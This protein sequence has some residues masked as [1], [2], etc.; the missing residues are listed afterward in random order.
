MSVRTMARVWERSQQCGNDLL[1]LLAIAD[2]A[3]DDGRAYPAVATLAAKCRMTARN[4]N[5][6]LADLRA[7]GELDVRM[8]EGPKGTNLYQIKIPP[9]GNVT[10]D[11]SVTLTE[12]SP[13]PDSSVPKP[14]TKPSA[15]PS[16]NHQEPSERVE[17]DAPDQATP[18]KPRKKTPIPFDT[19]ITQCRAEGVEAIPADDPIFFWA[20]A[21][22]IPAEWLPLVWHEFATRYSGHTKRYADWR[23]AFRNCVRSNWFK[24]WRIAS[25]GE[26]QLTTEGEMARR[27]AL[28]RQSRR[29][30]RAA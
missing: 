11:N 17:R 23:A 8:N 21:A 7:S 26:Y 20:E 2:F 3:D 22:G 14:L 28:D 29:Q 30:E 5:R 4:A 6:V 12:S 13:T 25:G 15:E 18:A 1:M 24:L 10:P 27:V 9:D 19:F 16:M